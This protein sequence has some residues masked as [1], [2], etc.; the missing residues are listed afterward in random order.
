MFFN[1]NKEPFSIVFQLVPVTG[2]IKLM[3][4]PPFKKKKVDYSLNQASFEI[5]TLTLNDDF[6]FIAPI[7][8][9]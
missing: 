5:F 7:L 1:V 4:N 8:K 6:I 3:Q 2:P 9:S